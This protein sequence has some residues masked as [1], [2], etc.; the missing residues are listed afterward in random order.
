MGRQKLWKL[1]LSVKEGSKGG[2]GS[3]MG[4]LHCWDKRGKFGR[5]GRVELGGHGW[6]PGVRCMSQTQ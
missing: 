5:G 2:C 1:E 4:G 3:G 6:G